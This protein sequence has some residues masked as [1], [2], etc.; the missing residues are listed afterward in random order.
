MDQQSLNL[1]EPM[2]YEAFPSNFLFIWQTTQFRTFIS[3]IYLWPSHITSGLR[4]QMTSTRV[5]L[6]QLLHHSSS[7][8]LGN[9]HFLSQKK[10][11]CWM[12]IRFSLQRLGIVHHHSVFLLGH[13]CFTDFT[14]CTWERTTS[15]RFP[16][17]V[18]LRSSIV[19]SVS[20]GTGDVCGVTC[21]E[22]LRRASALLRWLFISTFKLDGI[23]ICSNY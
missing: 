2:A 17:S 22:S 7:I 16:S 14:T 10:H 11:P 13:Q 19:H 15:S 8:C 18:E 5:C 4:L 23:I 21:Y 6:M 9:Q 3:N 1:G 20:A 12:L